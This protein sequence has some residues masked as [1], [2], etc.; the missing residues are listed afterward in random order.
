M[1]SLFDGEKM[2]VKELK[3]GPAV[4]LGDVLFDVVDHH[5]ILGGAPCN[6]AAHCTQAGLDAYAVAAVG[7]DDLGDEALRLLGNMGA[8][9]VRCGYKTGTVEASIDGEGKAH[10]VF[11]EDCAFDHL[12]LTQKHKKLAGMCSLLC[13]GTLC[14]RAEQSR[15][16]IREFLSLA[17]DALRI[18][19]V[20]L[21]GNYYSKELLL[22]SF[23]FC[24]VV[25][26][27]EDELPFLCETAGCEL[28]A[29]AL[30]DFLVRK[31]GITGL[32]YT[33]GSLGSDIYWGEEHSS[34]PAHQIKIA[35]T[36][37]A[38]DSFTAAFAA[39]L[40]SGRSVSCAHAIASRVAAYV[41]TCRGAVPQ[42][43]PELKA[44]F[45]DVTY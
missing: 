20:N 31:F 17:K 29:K 16:S 9:I 27:S 34:Y 1:V 8:A 38:G 45:A 44:L 19:D 6:F 36:I 33:A 5:A 3:S 18:F 15:N 25:K 37:G 40:V 22:S 13:F 32:I 43:T 14:Q 26:L 23:P 30:Y 24:D 21:R 28:S 42:W 2:L 41:C 7:N 35:D 10:Y 39:A 12:Q 4:G 11:D